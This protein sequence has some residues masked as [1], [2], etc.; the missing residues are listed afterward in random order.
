MAGLSR[1]GK[2]VIGFGDSQPQGQRGL[3]ATYLHEALV[4]SYKLSEIQFLS[5]NKQDL[6]GGPFLCLSW[7]NVLEWAVNS[8]SMSFLFIPS[9]TNSSQ[10]FTPHSSEVA[11]HHLTAG[12]HLANQEVPVA[13]D[14]R[15]KCES[16]PLLPLQRLLPLGFRLSTLLS[17]PFFS[18]L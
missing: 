11:L 12:F 5:I 13:F 15:S 4:E 17:G 10:H 2:K 7:Q 14:W 8:V 9:C 3:N 18:C 1:G 6:G 16:Q